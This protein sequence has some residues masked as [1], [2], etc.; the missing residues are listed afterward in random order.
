MAD[1]EGAYKTG[2]K[3]RTGRGFPSGMGTL[4]CR[5]YGEFGRI[6]RKWRKK[7]KKNGNAGRN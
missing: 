4:Q 2:E 5:E 3:L 6:L 1:M 7:R